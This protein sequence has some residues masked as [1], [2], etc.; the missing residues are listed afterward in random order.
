MTPVLTKTN[1]SNPSYLSCTY[2][3]SMKNC[4]AGYWRRSIGYTMSALTDDNYFKVMN[5]YCSDKYGKYILCSQVPDTRSMSSL[6]LDNATHEQLMQYE[7][8]RND[9]N[10]RNDYTINDYNNDNMNNE[11]HILDS[12]NH[13][14]TFKVL[15]MHKNILGILFI[16]Y[17]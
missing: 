1:I 15:F 11:T 7:I 9:Y 12:K 3:Y 14:S 5:D 4:I 17:M 8:Q 16:E 6:N 10:A 2:A 13:D